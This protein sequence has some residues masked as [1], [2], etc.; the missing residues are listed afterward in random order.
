MEFGETWATGLAPTR[1][2][3]AKKMFGEAGSLLNGDRWT[4]VTHEGTKLPRNRSSW[5]GHHQSE[6]PYVSLQQR[7]QPDY[8]RKHDRVPDDRFE[9]V[10]FLAELMRGS[11]GD[12][13]A[14]SVDHLAHHAAG[15][16]GGAN[17]NLSLPR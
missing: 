6:R 14:L 7:H 8:G 4:M 3:E 5:M 13:D 12:A 11:G 9:D 15:R 16:I 1:I 17:E 2:P 10:G